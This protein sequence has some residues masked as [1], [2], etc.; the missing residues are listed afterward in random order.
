MSFKLGHI[1]WNKGK[2]WPEVSVRLKGN[3]FWLG[4][5]HSDETRRK[6]SMILRGRKFSKEHCRKL[7]EVRSLQSVKT[8]KKISIALRGKKL[9]DE[10][11][12][13]ISLSLRR[14]KHPNWRGGITPMNR[15]VRYSLEYRNWRDRVFKRDNWTCVQCKRRGGELNA[16]HIKQFAF[17]PDIRFELDNGRTLCVPCHRK[18][19]TYGP[20]RK[21]VSKN[22]VNIT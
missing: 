14:E 22:P 13:N 10:H 17:Y 15:V 2:K 19:D 20:M 9:S 3:K 16:D 18:T 11:R 5:H 4:R 7:S 6:I 21:D 12:K 1:P 8:R